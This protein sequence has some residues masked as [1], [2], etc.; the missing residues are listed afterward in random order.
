M[1]MVVGCGLWH[2]GRGG[3][4]QR[5]PGQCQGSL[6]GTVA[7]HQLIVTSLI[8]IVGRWDRQCEAEREIR[9]TQTEERAL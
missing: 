8:Y 1:S 9:G 7:S 4:G 6:T 2:S 5:V 3:V